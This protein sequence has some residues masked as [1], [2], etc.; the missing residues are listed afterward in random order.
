MSVTVVFNHLWDLLEFRL[1][2]QNPSRAA[3]PGPGLVVP[4]GEGGL[5]VGGGPEVV[6]GLQQS[7]RL[8]PGLN[9]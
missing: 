9:K 2:L 6:G 8:S 4:D 3:L 7:L 1:W 5:Q